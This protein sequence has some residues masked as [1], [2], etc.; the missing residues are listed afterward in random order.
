MPWPEPLHG[1]FAP[2]YIE[3]GARH[4]RGFIRGEEQNTV[5]YFS[6]CAGSLEHGFRPE[7]FREFADFP[8]CVRRPL[9]VKQTR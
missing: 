3:N 1:G 6:R 5:G 8:A 4:K 9:F 7:F 2:I